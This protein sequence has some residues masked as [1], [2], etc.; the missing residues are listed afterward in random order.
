MK[1]GWIQSGN[2][3]YYLNSS[4]AMLVNTITPDGY[5]VDANGVWTTAASGSVSN[6]TTATVAEQNALRKAKSYL[7]F[8][9]FSYT[10]LIDQLE[11]E[12]FTS[13]EAKYGVDNC[14]ADWME[15]ALKQ[16]KSYL[17]SSSFSY[18]GLIDQL[19]YSGFTTAEAKYGTDNC[20][21]D[22]MEQAAKQAKSYL[23]IFDL[24]R[25]GLIDQL[26]YD[27]FTYEQAVYGAEQNGL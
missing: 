3:W 25:K 17:K 10:G 19:E 24:S 12:G 1:T 2:K 4:G 16:A 22:W 26:E 9:S 15:Q 5:R 27:G 7:K 8:S 18:V 21:A 20:G 23:K 11:Y 13:A 6:K 14:E